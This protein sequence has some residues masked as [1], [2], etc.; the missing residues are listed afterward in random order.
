MGDRRQARFTTRRLTLGAVA[1]GLWSASAAA[2]TA[3]HQERTV[4]PRPT[5]PA[6]RSELRARRRTICGFDGHEQVASPR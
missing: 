6:A 3:V 1:I 2:L 4:G 5:S